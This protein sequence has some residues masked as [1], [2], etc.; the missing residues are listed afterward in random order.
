MLISGP[1]LK[2]YFPTTEGIALL[3]H[4]DD[5]QVRLEKDG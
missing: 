5:K 3:L 4:R 2:K 1:S